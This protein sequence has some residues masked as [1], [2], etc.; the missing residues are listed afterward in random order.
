MRGRSIEN[1]GSEISYITFCGSLCELE[2]EYFVV[3]EV[4]V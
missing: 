3:D 2:H 1:L 4:H